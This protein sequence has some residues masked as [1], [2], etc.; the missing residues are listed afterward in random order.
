MSTKKPLHRIKTYKDFVGELTATYRRT[1]KPT[2]KVTSSLSAADFM[3]PYFD[4]CMDDHEEFKVLHLNRNNL[5][6]NVDHVSSGSDT[7]TMVPIKDIVRNALLIKTHG[8]L[9]FHNHPSSNTKPSDQD[10]E[11]TK[12]IKTAAAYF[13]IALLDH[14]I[15][16]RESYYSF[17]NEN[18]L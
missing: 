9:L 12:K 4:T 16:T 6:V 7:G 18:I 2:I 17:A 15:L 14:I 13:D 5:V 10:I 3:R 11:V 8:I 1:E